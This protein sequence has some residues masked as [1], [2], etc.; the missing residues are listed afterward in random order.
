MNFE[1]VF[2]YI[3]EIGLYQVLLYVLLGLPSYYS[4][5]MSISMAFLGYTPEHWCYVERLEDFPYE[6][7]KE[8][9]E[10]QEAKTSYLFHHFNMF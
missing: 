10:L 9:G 3:G 2:Q 8:V 4:G 5:Y 1:D 7:Q 6:T